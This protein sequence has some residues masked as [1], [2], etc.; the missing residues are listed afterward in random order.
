MRHVL[1]LAGA[2]SL[3]AGAALAA[4]MVHA[5]SCDIVDAWAAKVN[6]NDNYNIAPRLQLPKAFSD[7]ELVPVFG[8][9]VTNWTQEDVQAASQGLVACFQDAQ[10]RRDAAAA[11]ALA[12]A[13]RAL[14]GLVP[15]TNAALQKA[16]NDADA[17]KQQIDG[18]PDS[19]DL[20]RAIDIL[21]HANP[22]QPDQ[23]AYRP[24][25]RPAV[26]S[27]WRLAIAVMNLGDADREAL[28]KS[29]RDREGKMEADLGADVDKSIASASTDAAGI[30]AL[31]TAREKAMQIAD[32]DARQ[33]R[34]KSADDKAQQIRDTLK[35][36]KPA[37]WVPP[38]C[39]DLYRWSSAP[40]AQGGVAIANRTMFQAFS[41]DRVVPVFGASVADWTDADMAQFKALRA[42]CR[43][44][45]QPA[46][47]A[48][49]GPEAAELVQTANRGRWI[50]GADQPTAD[51][52]NLM[53]A[54][55][56]AEAV[57]ATDL[58][59]I[60]ALPDTMAA[61]MQIAQIVND[62]TLGGLTQ[63]DK[64][65]MIAAINAKRQ[66]VAAHATDAAIKGLGDVKLASL[67]DMKNLFAYVAQTM[68]TIPDPRGQEAFREA[69]NQTLQQ[70]TAKLLPEFKASLA[71]KPATLADIAG[72]QITLL[73]LETAP[74]GVV[75]TPAYQT[76]FTAMQNGRDAMVDSA[77]KAACADF[78]N[79]VGAGSD[80][81]QPVWDGREAMPLGEFLCEIDEHGT[82]NSYSGAGMFSSTVTLKATPLKQQ[83]Y[84]VSMHAVEVQQGKK[85][86][87][88]YDIKDSAQ[89]TDAS[90]PQGQPGYSPIPNGPVTVDAWEIF[91]PNLIG[92]NGAEDDTCIKTID[93]PNPD[94]LSAAEKVFW[95]HCW[96]FSNVRTHVKLAHLPKQQQ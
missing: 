94:Q 1:L 6:P 58:G 43:D 22:A 24:I 47:A 80:A 95:L 61:V 45:S 29:L 46:A 28:F 54:L 50:E 89:A 35:Q 41:D 51:A 31:M 20:A 19:P 78:D 90:A 74:F 23:N 69:F 5:P 38:S 37:V 15:R 55:H 70:Q 96:T 4:P 14:L 82:V 75:N 11:G 44:A 79:S 63:D 34:V 7:A 10:K 59:K 49:G 72:V 3:A 85:M 12:N 39:L 73:Q 62:P 8:V 18:L 68:P 40:N 26:D 21:L 67:T 56:K 87:V 65:K 86:L 33:K 93:S 77:R 30:I 2:L 92:L 52:R 9:A 81:D 13:N 42:M 84:T 60:Q 88:G 64:Q 27:F 71:S 17:A 53:G 66:A 25:P 76:Y 83:L 48:N 36:Q 16:K 91:V 57:M 32:A